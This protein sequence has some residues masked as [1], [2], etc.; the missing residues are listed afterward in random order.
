MHTPTRTVAHVGV[1]EILKK[2]TTTT[3]NLP[4]G[5]TNWQKT[6]NR[7]VQT[8]LDTALVDGTLGFC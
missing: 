5:A 7:D 6:S 1:S 2:K 8:V 3:L 4:I